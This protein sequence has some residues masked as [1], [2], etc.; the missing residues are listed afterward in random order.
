MA[1]AAETIVKVPPLAES[2]TEGTIAKIH[3]AE[4]DYIETDEVLAVLE[5][6][7]TAV[8]I[9]APA[10]GK[11]SK[12]FVKENDVVTPGQEIA[13][14]DTSAAKPK[15]AAK[16]AEKAAQKETSKEAPKDAEERGPKPQKEAKPE[17]K[18]APKPAAAPPP[19][20]VPG[21]RNERR[22]PMSRMRLTI[23]DRLKG[24]QNTAA[25][26]TTFNEVDMH[27]IMQL[28]NKYKDIFAEKTGAKLGFMSAF[29]KASTVAL[30]AFPDV[31]SSIDG[32]DL[33]YHDYCDIS[34]AVATPTGLVVPVLRNTENMSFAGVE[35]A[36]AA[37]G[38]KA[39][40]NQL[41]IEDMTG[42]TF[43]I[44]N[45]GVYGSLMGTP[46]LNPPQ[47]AILGMHAIFKRPVVL[48]DSDQVVVRPMMYVALT[49]DHRVID[50][51]TAVQFLKKI[52][53]CIEDPARMLLDV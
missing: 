11:V 10:S 38:Q 45:G 41:T 25:M 20:P 42:G 52:K 6:A 51:A 53:E 43:T 29:V 31:N 22:V 23:A 50:G 13:K 4:G 37:L 14:I 46:I 5:T 39:R 32:K 7:K 18:P 17:A 44:S 21:S 48:G 24:A 35:H 8:D 3:K 26:L 27:N 36:I 12:I 2:I 33:V 28:R 15:Q 40:K 30:R 47:T 1:T 34:V 19:P 16:P 49:Y 9:N